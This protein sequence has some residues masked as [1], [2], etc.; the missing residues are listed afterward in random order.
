[1][2][3][4]TATLDGVTVVKDEVF[5]KRFAETGE[6]S[7]LGADIKVCDNTATV[8]GVEFLRGGAVKALDLRGG[9]ALVLAGLKAQ[10]ETVIENAE[11]IDRG[12]YKLDEKLRKLGADVTRI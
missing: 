4:V 6:L 3:V 1:M 8:R 5:K 2:I 9:A 7:K 10:G 12:Y 11:L